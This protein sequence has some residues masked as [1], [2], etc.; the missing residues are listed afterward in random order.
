MIYSFHNG[1]PIPPTSPSPVLLISLPT[2]PLATTSLLKGIMYDLVQ[3]YNLSILQGIAYIIT[4]YYD[5][6]DSHNDPESP[7][8]LSNYYLIY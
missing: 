7:R 6:A 8:I 4:G 5:I 3:H 1:K 2:T